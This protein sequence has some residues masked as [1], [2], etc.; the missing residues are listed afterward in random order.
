MVDR[1]VAHQLLVEVLQHS[2][3]VALLPLSEVV[4]QYSP[5]ELSFHLLCFQYQN[6]LLE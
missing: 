2:L 5:S 4:N 3:P 1:P 6:Y